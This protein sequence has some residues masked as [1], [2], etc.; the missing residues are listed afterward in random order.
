MKCEKQKT[1]DTYTK[2]IKSETLGSHREG[3]MHGVARQQPKLP[4]LPNN[5]LEEVLESK[6]LRFALK[7]VI[8]NK[9]CPGIDGM[10]VEKLT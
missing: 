2:G 5:L 8:K 6:N 1:S 3:T 10:T 9:G 7:S 4:S